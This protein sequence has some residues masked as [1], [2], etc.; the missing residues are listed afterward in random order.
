MNLH[1]ALNP[2]QSWIIHGFRGKPEMASQLTKA[3]MFIS[4]GEKFNPESVQAIPVDR[5]LVE[6]DESA[7]PLAEIYLAIATAKGCEVRELVAV[8]EIFGFE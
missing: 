7:M 1:K 5:I 4:F 8:N 6:S 2:K 3:G